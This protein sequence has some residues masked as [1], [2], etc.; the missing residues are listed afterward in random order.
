MS[1]IDRI[2]HIIRVKV[3][4][5]FKARRPDQIAWSRPLSGLL[6]HVGEAQPLTMHQSGGGTFGPLWPKGYETPVG[7]LE[8][9]LGLSGTVPNQ[10]KLWW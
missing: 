2:G 5:L 3:G 4:Q 7:L 10:T 1:A 8:A 6:F 9:G